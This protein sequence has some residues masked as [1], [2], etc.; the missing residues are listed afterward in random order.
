MTYKE[1]AEELVLKFMRLQEQN[2]NWFH[3]E[4]A[5]KC[6]LIAV[7]EKLS[8]ARDYQDN[9]MIRYLNEVKQEIEKL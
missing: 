4:L 7:D 2:Y 9:G 6:A 5:K 8:M 1:E 3:S